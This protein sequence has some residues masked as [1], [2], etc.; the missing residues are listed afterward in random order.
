MCVEPQPVART[1]RA[2]HT[3]ISFSLLTR[4]FVA[5]AA[6]AAIAASVVVAGFF[7]F[8]LFVLFRFIYSFIYVG[9]VFICLVDVSVCCAWHSSR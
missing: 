8:C 9:L 7:M 5:A 2:N 4:L 1:E 6:V 3:I